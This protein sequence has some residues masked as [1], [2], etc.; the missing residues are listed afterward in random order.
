MKWELFVEIA[1]VLGAANALVS[2]I[3]KGY[4]YRK[5]VLAYLKRNFSIKR[6]KS[7]FISEFTLIEATYTPQ[8]Q[9]KILKTPFLQKSER[10]EY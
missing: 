7:G 5:P 1:L 9:K 2:I 6:F 8:L 10:L 3:D 4:T